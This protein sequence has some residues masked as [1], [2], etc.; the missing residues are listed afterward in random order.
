M[1]SEDKLEKLIQKN[2][3][4]MHELTIRIENLDRLVQDLLSEMNVAPEQLTAYLEKKEHFT[5]D[6]WQ[7]LLKQK[8]ILD[9]KL[10]QELE[11]IRNP[12]EVKKKYQERV[13]KNWIFVR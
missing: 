9:D 11:H 1:S 3:I 8:K 4:A 5:D 10:K 2:E 13:D 6:N 12:L 7:E